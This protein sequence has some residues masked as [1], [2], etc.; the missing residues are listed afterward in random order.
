MSVAASDQL[1]FIRHGETNWNRNGRL[2]GQYDVPLNAKGRDQASSAGRLLQQFGVASFAFFASPLQRARE[3]MLRVRAA[4]NLKPFEAYTVDDRLKELTFGRWEGLTWPEIRATD[5]QAVQQR[6]L[7][8]WHFV[9]PEGE[10]YAMLR[11]RVEPWLGALNG[12]AVV[13]AHG[14]IARVFLVELGGVAPSTAAT[15]AIHQGR[16]LIFAGRTFRWV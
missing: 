5:P 12:S 14:G 8:T 11:E 16:L 3:T 2:Q 6:R 4:C 9:P 7:D 13:V 15:A 1:I 10:S